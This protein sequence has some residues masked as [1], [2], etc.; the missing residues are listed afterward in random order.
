MSIVEFAGIPRSGKTATV[1]SLK[2]HF[3]GFVIH[4]EMINIGRSK[5]EDPFEFNYLYAQYCVDRQRDPLDSQDVNLV[6]RG[7]LDRIAYGIACVNAGRI[8]SDQI[9]Q[10]LAILEPLSGTNTLTFIFLVS[11]EISHSRVRVQKDNPVQYIGF[12]Q[13]LYA[14]YKNLDRYKNIVFVPEGLSIEQ[15]VAFVL[16]ELQAKSLLRK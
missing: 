12:L 11:P 10:Y 4:P 3:P 16:S 15:Q 14:A 9:P 2:E 8:K 1:S 6:E 13:A 5:V 7:I